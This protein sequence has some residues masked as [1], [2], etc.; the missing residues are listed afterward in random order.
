MISK[1]YPG[2]PP[3]WLRLQEK[4]SIDTDEPV[5]VH[6]KDPDGLFEAGLVVGPVVL[7]PAEGGCV[8]LHRI[9][10]D[11]SHA[12]ATKIAATAITNNFSFEAYPIT[13]E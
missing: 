1:E 2:V 10:A 13:S 12:L 3:L 7:N 5:I 11:E 9:C 8:L 4:L 6:V